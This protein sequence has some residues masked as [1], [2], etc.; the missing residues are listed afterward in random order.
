VPADLIA[1]IRVP[2]AESQDK[3][4]IYTTRQPTN[5]ELALLELAT[6]EARKAIGAKM[7]QLY[8]PAPARR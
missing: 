2:T 4:E 8:G 6:A 1:D 7:E 3:L 5:D